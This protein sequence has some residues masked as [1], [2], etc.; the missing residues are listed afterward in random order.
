MSELG[1]D[2]EQQHRQQH[3]QHRRRKKHKPRRSFGCLAVLIAFAVLAGGAFAAY[4]VGMSALKDRLSPPGDY[5]GPGTGSVVIEVQDGDAASDIAATLVAGGVVKSS[6]AFTDAA[7][8]DPASLGIQVGFYQMRHEMSAEGALKVLVDP[9]NMMQNTVAFPEGWT[10]DQI[11]AQLAKKTDFSAKQYTAVLGNP[12]SIGLP[13]FAENN[14]EGYLFPATYEI[15]PN[16]TAAS[17]LTSM[18]NRYKQAAEEFDLEGGAAKLGMSPQ[19]VMTVASLIQ[20]EARNDSDFPKVSRVI[21]NRL[22]K[23]MPL[24]FDSTVH[25][26]VGKDGSVGTSDEDRDVDSPYNTYKVAGLPPSPIMAPGDQAIRAALNPADG[27]WL[28]F[29]TTNP[30]TGETKFAESFD[31]HLK[32]KAEFDDW[33]AESDHC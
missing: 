10:V 6:D 27:P 20:A 25:Y 28:Y 1:L 29:V 23:P 5:A 4:T 3:R 22:D 11:V 8:A 26:A 7:I 21:Y 30:D 17:I 19:E 18:V 33:C 15:R 31:E 32:N 12:K 9:G 14:P 16:A 2:L 24:Q 13:D